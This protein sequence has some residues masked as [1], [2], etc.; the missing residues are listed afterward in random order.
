MAAWLFRGD[1]WR[2]MDV[3]TDG[4]FQ[5]IGSQDAS[6]LLWQAALMAA[7]LAAVVLHARS[8]RQREAALRNKAMRSRS[9]LRSRGA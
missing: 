1:R 9:D 4:I 5:Y 6:T 2:K 3:I 7:A 8:R